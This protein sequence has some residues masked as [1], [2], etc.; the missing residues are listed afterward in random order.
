MSR[1]IRGAAL[2]ALVALA[3]LAPAQGATAQYRGRLDAALR[4]VAARRDSGNLARVRL[5]QDYATAVVHGNVTVFTAPAYVDSVRRAF[6]V[7]DAALVGWVLPRPP[8]LRAEFRLRPDWS[9]V[10][11]AGTKEATWFLD[12]LG[13]G[14]DEAAANWW[15]GVPSSREIGVSLATVDRSDMNVL[16]PRSVRQWLNSQLAA[17]DPATLWPAIYVSLATSAT[18]ISRSCLLGSIKAC[19]QTLAIDRAADPLTEWYSP[20]ARHA[21]V[22]PLRVKHDDIARNIDQRAPGLIGSC[23]DARQDAACTRIVREW[24]GVL[25]YGDPLQS[26]IGREGLLIAAL[27]F[28]GAR[29]VPALSGKGELGLEES[30]RAMAGADVDQVVEAWLARVRAAEPET[31]QSMPSV[32]LAA[33][34]WTLVAGGLALRG[35]RW[36]LR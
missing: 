23:L 3:R 34:L 10:D 31:V 2:L 17:R 11:S 5:R 16:L 14:G 35:S 7:K 12:R 20:T 6:A 36:V 8:E 25:S 33:L 27:E 21:M 30:L 32:L 24:F 26:S 22:A 18:T 28:P 29:G 13:P 15:I 9:R 19:R 1:L 4:E